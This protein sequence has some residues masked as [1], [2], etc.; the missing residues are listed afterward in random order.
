MKIRQH[1]LLVKTCDSV[2]LLWIE[3]FNKRLVRFYYTFMETIKY[4]FQSKDNLCR[5]YNIS[6]QRKRKTPR[7]GARLHLSEG[8][9]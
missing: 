1:D 2:E 9:Y 3:L 5:M 7:C 8:Q 6:T 4:V